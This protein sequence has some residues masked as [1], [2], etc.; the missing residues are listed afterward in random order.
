MYNSKEITY[1]S[2]EKRARA[3]IAFIYA[4][5]LSVPWVFREHFQFVQYVCICVLF[6][7]FRVLQPLSQA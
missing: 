2:D 5:T 6:L 1:P 7:L 4:V 3:A